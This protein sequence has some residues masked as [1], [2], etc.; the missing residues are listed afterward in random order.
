MYQYINSWM[1]KSVAEDYVSSVL[2]GNTPNKRLFSS[3]SVD[4]SESDSPPHKM[5]QVE[6]EF[7]P[8]KVDP[9]LGV[10][11]ILVNFITQYNADMSGIKKEIN[12]IKSKTC[13]TRTLKSEPDKSTASVLEKVGEVSLIVSDLTGKFNALRQE[14]DLKVANIESRIIC[15][16]TDGVP[17]KEYDIDTTC[18]ITGWRNKTGENLVEECKTMLTKLGVSKEVIRAKRVGNFDGKSGV[19]KMELSSLQDKID[20]LNKK[21]ELQHIEPYTK[22]FIRS[23]Q[24]H[25]QRLLQQHTM[26]LLELLGKKDDYY[27]NG[28]GKL[29]KKRWQRDG[30]TLQSNRPLGDVNATI[31]AS[32][33]KLVKL[34]E[35]KPNSTTY[36]G[37]V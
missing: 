26:E 18:V 24:S 23:S 10:K 6:N 27:F 7:T 19:V 12:D 9:D 3:I 11:D 31:L 32:L 5:S 20:V 13:S 21:K 2:L 28:S 8:I 34:H 1:E 17:R 36:A 16:E 37:A 4:S 35:V 29:I 30:P 25:E 22:W 15:L 33:E 14:Y